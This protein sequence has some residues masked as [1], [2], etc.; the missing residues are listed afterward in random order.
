MKGE[1]LDKR[2]IIPKAQAEGI[3]PLT[4]PLP[5]SG[6][7]T[8]GSILASGTACVH[9]RV[10]GHSQCTFHICT[11]ERALAHRGNIDCVNMTRAD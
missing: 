11:N 6:V 9:R 8:S 3:V 5:G 4:D 1:E 2:E 7:Q 10:L